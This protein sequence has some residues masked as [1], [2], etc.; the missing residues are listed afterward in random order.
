VL[1]DGRK[2][3]LAY[4]Y[5]DGAH[6]GIPTLQ[7]SPIAWSRDGWPSVGQPLTAARLTTFGATEY[8][9][10]TEE[11]HPRSLSANAPRLV[12]QAILAGQETVTLGPSGA[13][14]IAVFAEPRLRVENGV[15]VPQSMQ[16]KAFDVK[17]GSVTWR[18]QLLGGDLRSTADN[19]R[20]Y[21]KLQLPLVSYDDFDFKPGDLKYEIFAFR[22][23]DGRAKWR[24]PCPNGANPLAWS[25]RVYY[26]GREDNR[27]NNSLVAL[28]AATGQQ[29]WRQP[30]HDVRGLFPVRGELYAY[31]EDR[32]PEGEYLNT[33]DPA[34]GQTVQRL[35]FYPLFRSATHVSALAWLPQPRVLVGAIEQNSTPGTEAYQIRALDSQGKPAWDCPDTGRFSVVGGI[36]VCQ[37]YSPP[38][39]ETQRTQGP[40]GLIALDPA[41]GRQLWRRSDLANDARGVE[42]NLGAWHGVAVVLQGGRLYGLDPRTGKTVWMVDAIPPHKTPSVTTARIVGDVIVLAAS[43]AADRSAQVRA[44]AL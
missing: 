38:V 34:T 9:K 21:V 28:D 31:N 18:K 19:E 43:G 15:Y 40:H 5:Y 27:A 22:W 41:N 30:S 13:G 36:L 17:G 42:G 16:M 24:A 20:V 10:F 32:D 39:T 8:A 2:D 3:Y 37:G 33:I 44:F 6:N 14:R 23:S 29:Q 11:M 7:I 35:L 12:W 26:D 4:H 25:G 1:H